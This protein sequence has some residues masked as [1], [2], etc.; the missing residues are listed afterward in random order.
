MPIN[1]PTEQKELIALVDRRHPKYHARLAHWQFC[2]AT[3]DGGR[4]WFQDNIFKYVKEGDKEYGE[5]VARAYRFN[6]TRE[7][8]NLVTK[9]IFKSGVIR[10]RDEAPDAL[11]DF[12]R[13]S[14]I[15]GAS[16]DEFMGSI[17]NLSSIYGRVW[18]VTD[19]LLP[20]NVRSR[21]EAKEVNARV[22]A[23][24]VTPDDALDYAYD[25]SG[26]LTWFMYRFS[27]RDDADPVTSTGQINTRYV[28]MTRD[29]WVVLEERKKGKGG[30]KREIIVIDRRTN[31]L[32]EV[33]A[34]AV[35]D[36][37]ADD[38]YDVPALI[39][40]TAYLDRAI[41]NYLSNLDAIIQDQSF[42]QLVIPAQGLLPGEDSHNKMLDMGTK[43]MFLFD[44]EGGMAPSFI[45]PDASQAEVI[46]KVVNKI[47]AEI[48]HS[49]GMS[50]ERTKQDNAVGIDNS[51][52]VAK[53]Y[54]FERVNSLLASKAAVLDRAENELSR[55]ICAWSGVEM[56][57][58]KDGD[59]KDL[60]K[61]PE[62]FDVRSLYD[63]FE[64]AD[65]LSLL[66]APDAARR[67][68]MASLLKKL[69]PRLSEEKLAEIEADLAE[70]P[71]D[72]IEQAAA[73]T[74]ATT[75]PTPEAPL[76]TPKKRQGQVTKNTK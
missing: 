21:A 71:L 42:S 27:H 19:S 62:S 66:A 48:Y 28:I 26:K 7:V 12:W 3:Y 22:Y 75:P 44:G 51:S 38:P 55:Q 16:I 50:G 17:C 5:R 8:V 23:Y 9:Y 72:P 18:L 69:F 65:N 20:A 33:P 11:K 68:Q 53:A 67:E 63:E 45:S 15:S 74:E 36:R 24:A 32:G 57:K 29:E 73:M 47:I 60:V 64:V 52:G 4:D 25:V 41:A 43:R 14:N 30:D 61:Y 35:D 37:A 46:L 70:W 1:L 54:D 6:H 2:R 39:G 59:T 76:A 56:P 10:N 13:N 49:V 58:D 31:E 40:D 34:F